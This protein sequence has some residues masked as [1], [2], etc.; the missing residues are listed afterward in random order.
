MRANAP[1]APWSWLL[2]PLEAGLFKMS[3][4]PGEH[5]SELITGNADLYP[6]FS[7]SR[8]GA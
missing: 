5:V 6:A 4:G 3:S 8:F 2:D 1:T 7:L